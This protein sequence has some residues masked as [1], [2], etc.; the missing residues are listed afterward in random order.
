MKVGDLVMR[1][2][3]KTVGVIVKVTPEYRTTEYHVFV[4]GVVRYLESRHIEVIN[5]GR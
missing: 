1:K 4:G 2:V 3:N 5:E